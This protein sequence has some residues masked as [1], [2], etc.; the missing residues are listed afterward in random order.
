MDPRTNQLEPGDRVR[1]THAEGRYPT[2]ERVH[3]YTRHGETQTGALFPTG[4]DRCYPG[5]LWK[6]EY[7]GTSWLT[8]CPPE[9]DTRRAAQLAFD[10]LTARLNERTPGGVSVTPDFEA[11]FAAGVRYAQARARERK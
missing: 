2:Q 6:I 10:V 1:L 8:P 9:G 3:V 5:P 7:I 11:A 4:Y